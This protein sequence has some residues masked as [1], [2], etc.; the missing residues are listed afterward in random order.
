MSSEIVAYLRQLRA[1]RPGVS[2]PS[3]DIT[4]RLARRLR[5]CLPPYLWLILRINPSS[6][7]VAGTGPEMLFAVGDPQLVGVDVV[8]FTISLRADQTI[9]AT[10]HIQRIGSPV[11]ASLGLHAADAR[12][13]AQLVDEFLLAQ[14]PDI[15]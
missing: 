12:A 2:D 9:G 10:L 8:S 1:A 6:C 15:A 3:V 4:G 13:N 14:F 11:S 5:E 7:A